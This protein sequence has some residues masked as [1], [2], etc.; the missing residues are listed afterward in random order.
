MYVVFR[1]HLPG[2]GLLKAPIFSFALALPFYIFAPATYGTQ[3]LI[4]P[5]ESAFTFAPLPG[6]MPPCQLPLTY[7]LLMALP[8]V[9]AGM[10]IAGFVEILDKR[11]PNAS[12]SESAML[13]WANGLLTVIASI[14]LLL[15]LLATMFSTGLVQ[16]GD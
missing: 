9:A 11:L 15:L 1:T 2:P 5:W 6:S 10:G 3:G 16:L 13:S 8:L 4:S 12:A 7:R 14:G